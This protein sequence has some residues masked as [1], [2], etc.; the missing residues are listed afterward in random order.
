M[1]LVATLAT[2]LVA[3]VASAAPERALAWKSGAHW[4]AALKVQNS[5][6]V[7][8]RIRTAMENEPACVAW[9]CNYPDVPACVVGVAVD[10]APWFDAYHYQSCGAFARRL[11]QNALASTADQKTKDQ[12]IAFAAGWL[13]HIV[14]DLAVH[15][16]L[17]NPE[18][19]VFIDPKADRDHHGTLEGWADPVVWRDPQMGGEFLKAEDYAPASL[20]GNNAGRLYKLFITGPTVA[21]TTGALTSPGYVIEDL[22]CRV[23]KEVILGPGNVRGGNT[24]FND[25]EMDRDDLKD[26]EWYFAEVL[27]EGNGYIG[28]FNKLIDYLRKKKL[29]LYSDYQKSWNALQLN[30]TA[31]KAPHAALP[32]SRISRVRAAWRQTW[33]DATILLQ[34]AEWGDYSQFLDSWVADKGVDGRSVGSLNVIVKTGHKWYSWLDG[35]GTDKNVYFGM[36]Y[37]GGAKKEWKLDHAGAFYDDFEVNDSDIFYLDYDPAIEPWRVEKIWIRLGA[38][39]VDF[40]PYW[41]M[42]TFSVVMNDQV[43]YRCSEWQ[44]VNKPGTSRSATWYSS[45]EGHLNPMVSVGWPTASNGRFAPMTRPLGDSIVPIVRNN[46]FNSWANGQPVCWVPSNPSRVTEGAAIGMTTPCGGNSVKVAAVSPELAIT[47]RTTVA[48]R[49]LVRPEA[50]YRVSVYARPVAFS[51]TVPGTMQRS[52]VSMALEFL[53]SAGAVLGRVDTTLDQWPVFPGSEWAWMHCLGTA[54]NGATS[55]RVILGVRSSMQKSNAAVFDGVELVRDNLTGGSFESYDDIGMDTSRQP[56]AWFTM[57]WYPGTPTY[58]PVAPHTDGQFGW[59][60]QSQGGLDKLASDVLVKPG[61]TFRATVDALTANA[62]NG[63]PTAAANVRLLLVFLNSANETLATSEA[64]GDAFGVNG[65]SFQTMDVVGTA[66][67]GT[68]VA[69]VCVGVAGAGNVAIFD[70]ATLGPYVRSAMEVQASATKVTAGKAV[71]LNVKLVDADSQQA[72]LG[73]SATVEELRDA[74]WTPVVTFPLATSPTDYDFY[75]TRCTDYRIVMPGDGRRSACVSSV[76]HVDVTASLT[77]LTA[78]TRARPGQAIAVSV[79]LGPGIRPAA[80]LSSS[81][82]NVT[83]TASGSFA[84]RWR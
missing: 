23:N 60:L 64:A 63:T 9:G 48:Q 65:T 57:F 4:A 34:N 51:N 32:D 72:L 5:L 75:P 69:R 82:A 84:R 16:L 44:H 53:D 33:E 6:P 62:A 80:S 73:H 14:G 15:G 61:S 35:P 22:V 31:F 38:D 21:G 20:T 30:G 41:T 59:R 71:T 1:A 66:P 74:A 83:R 40:F 70:R 43:I 29:H 47:A 67:A 46:N 68:A 42:G 26:C 58:G 79:M 10:R 77:R 28:P 78:P 55:A 17:V 11:L 52:D 25:D 39:G 36:Q 8:S 50:D 19:G 2:V 81:S 27:A 7:G 12:Q 3:G 37:N 49:F 13:T 54:P 24:F 18:S 76:A 45:P 56:N